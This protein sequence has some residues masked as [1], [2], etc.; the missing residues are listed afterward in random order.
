MSSN[1]P[2]EGERVNGGGLFGKF[3][4]NQKLDSK[5]ISSKLYL[6]MKRYDNG[7]MCSDF[8]YLSFVGHFLFFYLS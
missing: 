3:K 6:N 4:L 7:K 1:K 5:K 2:Q 8:Y